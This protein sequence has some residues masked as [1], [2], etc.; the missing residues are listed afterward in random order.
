MPAGAVAEGPAG[1][2]GL[3]PAGGAGTT[4]A[5]AVPVGRPVHL[6]QTVVAVT[7]RVLVRVT[8]TVR[9]LVPLVVVV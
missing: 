3:E 6:W 8:G 9:V 4:V 7:V 2:T 5:V 1:A